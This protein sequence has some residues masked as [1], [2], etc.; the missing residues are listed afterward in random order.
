MSGRESG[1][2][3]PRWPG[4]IDFCQRLIQSQD[5]GE[6]ANAVDRLDPAIQIGFGNFRH[7]RIKSAGTEQILSPLPSY[8]WP[9]YQNF[10]NREIVV[11]S[12]ALPHRR[13]TVIR[14]FG[15]CV[16][17]R[18]FSMSPINR[19]IQL[20]PNVQLWPKAALEGDGGE[21]PVL[22]KADTRGQCPFTR[23]G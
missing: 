11:Q 20:R 4:G 12:V 21:R 1:Q 22:G 2:L 9:D 14:T 6:S 13:K 23:P 16:R 8:T 3:P 15:P 18:Q 19:T 10:L 5:D 17:F 7:R